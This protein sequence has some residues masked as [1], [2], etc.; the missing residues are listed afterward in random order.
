M[1]SESTR[2]F[3][4]PGRMSV[5]RDVSIKPNLKM[6][7]RLTLMVVGM[8]FGLQVCSGQPF[9]YK[10]NDLLLGFRKTGTFQANYELVIDIG[11]GTN[12]TQLS[13]GSTTKVTSFSPTQ[14]SDAFPNT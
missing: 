1:S 7:R 6:I 9:V 4:R 12:Y 5:P 3:S 14:L 13:A 11:Q 2:S 8:G 10:D